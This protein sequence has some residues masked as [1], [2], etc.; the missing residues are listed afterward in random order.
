MPQHALSSIAYRGRFAPSPT[1]PLHF[2]SLV[3]AVA[4]FLQARANRGSWLVRVEDLDP[5]RE[6]PGSLA[7]I[8][9]SLE[10]HA[11]YW[12]EAIVY[13][14]QR[15]ALYQEQLEILIKQ[16]SVFACH[17]SRKTIA[18]QQQ[19]LGINVYPG[20]CRDHRIDPDQPHAL[21]LRTP[22]KI[23][24]F[25]DLIQG[26]FSQHVSQQVGDFVLRRADGWFAYQLAVVIDDALQGINEVV[27]GCD[28]L[29]N[30]PRQLLLQ[31]LLHFPAPRYAHV[32][33]AVNARGEKLSK[34]TRAQPLDDTRP[35]ANLVNAL[36]FLG[37][38]AP[39]EDQF[40]RPE[41]VLLWACTHWQLDRV[42][43]LVKI[44]TDR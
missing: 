42:P 35:V 40:E 15:L 18:E 23:I 34:Q 29:D 12:D 3:S 31:R 6:S 25:E 43:R 17:C 14:S 20:S 33:I 44:I 1:G 28:L 2:G 13:Q 26:Y 37:Q 7:R 19:K 39:S 27:R 4:S 8:L 22:A 36:R 5:P 38:A 21:R 41:D 10:C 24:G 9:N 32:P 11:L 30:T 16:D